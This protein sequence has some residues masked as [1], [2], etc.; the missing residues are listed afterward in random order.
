[1]S[2]FIPILIEVPNIERKIIILNKK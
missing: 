2:R 1:M